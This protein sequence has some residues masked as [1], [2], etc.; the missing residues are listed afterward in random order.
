MTDNEQIKNSQDDIDENVSYRSNEN[1]LIN[2][3]L[4]NDRKKDLLDCL[5]GC[6]YGQA[7][8]DAYGL[9]TEF[10]TVAHIK[11][12]YPNPVELIPFPDYIPNSHACRW[13]KGDWTDDTDQWILVMEALMEPDNN[14]KMFARKLSLWVRQGFPEFNDFGGLGLGINVA[15][16][17]NSSGYL[18]NPLEASRI[19]WEESNRQVAP[20]GAVMRCSSSGIVNYNDIEKV[21]SSAI[22]MC[23]TTHFDPRCVASCVSICLAVAYMLQTPDNSD[24]ESLIA[25]VQQETLITLGDDLSPQYQEEFLWHTSKDRTLDD[26]RLDDERVIGYTYKCLASGFYGLRSTR[27][28]SET[29][30]DLI[31]HGGDADTNGAVCGTMYGVRYGYH[32]LPTEWLRAMPYKKW[33]DQKILHLLEHMNLINGTT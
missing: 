3:V 5:L 1:D 22:S 32:S 2:N 21:K 28:F 6:A 7:L 4:K 26:L 8:G 30:N 13:K 24:I 19:V 9:S 20:N 31:R 11:N 10:Q 25:R 12:L 17:I 16:V 18:E 27:S 33:F 15:K 23:Q 29:L 14:A